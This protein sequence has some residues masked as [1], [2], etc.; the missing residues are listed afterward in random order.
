MAGGDS[1]AVSAVEGRLS[2]LST[3]SDEKGL[4]R[5]GKVSSPF[6]SLPSP[7]SVLLFGIGR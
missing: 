5:R 7:V 2:E 6:Q 4:P 3:N 1:A